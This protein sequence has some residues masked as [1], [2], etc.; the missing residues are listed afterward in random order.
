[1][2]QNIYTV[3]CFDFFHQGHIN[4]LEGMK[5]YGQKIIVGIHDDESIRKLKNLTP[6]KHQPFIQRLKN[7]KPYCDR[8]F[9]IAGTDPSPFLEAYF[10]NEDNFDTSLFIRADDNINFPGIEIVKSKMNIK[11]LPYTSGISSTEIR[12]TL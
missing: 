12:K 5:Q 9:V 10:N 4:L 11:Y 7:V 2:Y 3:G 8:V 6:D 1:M